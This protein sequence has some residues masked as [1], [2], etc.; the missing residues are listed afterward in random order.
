M[1][2]LAGGAAAAQGQSPFDPAHPWPKY[3]HDERNSCRSPYRGPHCEP[4]LRWWA[5]LP[6]GDFVQGDKVNHLMGP[7]IGRINGVRYVFVGTREEDAERGARGHLLVYRFHPTG[8]YDPQAGAAAPLC[9]LDLGAPVNSTPLVLA[10]QR[11]IVQTQ[12]NLQCWDFS[13]WNPADPGSGPVR[14]WTLD[15]SSESSSPTCGFPTRNLV[16]AFVYAQGH[17][18]DDESL[19]KIDPLNFSYA[20]IADLAGGG[21]S[22]QATPVIGPVEGDMLQRN[23]VY[24]CTHGGGQTYP[25]LFA[26]YADQG[27]CAWQDA[28]DGPADSVYGAMG[29]PGI[30]DW[31]V[32]NDSYPEEADLFIASDDGYLWGFNNTMSWDKIDGY[33]HYPGT[34]TY[35]SSTAALARVVTSIGVK[36]Y[37]IFWSES[38]TPPALFL[39]DFGSEL[40]DPVE[41]QRTYVSLGTDW[42]FGAP[43]LDSW[44]RF[45][46]QTPGVWQD[47]P[48]WDD[49]GRRVIGYKVELDDQGDDPTWAW[50]GFSE[51]WFYPDQHAF[52]PGVT[53]PGWPAYHAPL[54][55]D[56]DGTLLCIAWREFGGQKTAYII[57]LRPLVGDFNGDGVSNWDDAPA[58][59]AARMNPTLWETNY[60]ALLGINRLGVGDANNDGLFNSSDIIPIRA[61]WAGGGDGDSPQWDCSLTSW[62]STLSRRKAHDAPLRDPRAIR[63]RSWRRTQREGPAGSRRR[64]HRGPAVLADGAGPVRPGIP[65]RRYLAQ[66]SGTGWG[67]CLHL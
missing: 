27:P 5:T 58:L 33:P 42:V 12:V 14:R 26:V 18:G 57:A 49:R 56:E 19:F 3:G 54:A 16:S 41:L 7:A 21:D 37:M 44:R 38:P 9:A 47:P 30:F 1:F 48:P 28:L 53:E 50:I 17:F 55:M 32:G 51:D 65:R 10:Q 60:G 34:V 39:Y 13:A 62:S 24:A 67:V 43:V 46:V 20:T 11:V 29:S 45:F 59:I 66:R 63:A 64:G 36:R 23:F 31:V 61:R 52:V 6:T 35:I 22:Y 2:T 8:A 4:E 15:V 25:H 40:S